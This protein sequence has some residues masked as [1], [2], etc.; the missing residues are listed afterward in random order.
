MSQLIPIYHVFQ[1]PLPSEKFDFTTLQGT[2][3]Q[4][5]DKLHVTCA[6]KHISYDVAPDGKHLGG[7]SQLDVYV[8][9]IINADPWTKGATGELIT[10]LGRSAEYIGAQGYSELFK[11]DGELYTLN[12]SYQATVAPTL[13]KIGEMPG[14][15]STESLYVKLP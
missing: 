8:R 2:V 12:P 15:T 4:V 14:T 11:I 13:S 6:A 5:D 1:Y 10:N 3:V 7:E 9:Q